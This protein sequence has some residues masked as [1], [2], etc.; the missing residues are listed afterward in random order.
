METLLQMASRKEFDANIVRAI[1]DEQSLFPIG[2][3][4]QLAD[5]RVA[6]VVAS[7][8]EAATRPVIAVISDELG[9][10]LEAPERVNLLERTD[11]NIARPLP[12]TPSLSTVDGLVGF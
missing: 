5:G 10:V 2:S 8:P 12:N 11:I 4:V 6:R 7:N 9:K 1:L 3:L